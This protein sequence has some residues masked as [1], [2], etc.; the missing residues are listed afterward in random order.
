MTNHWIDLKNTNCA[1]IIGSNAAENHPISFKWLLKA[2]EER[3]ARI[4]SVDPRFTRTSSQADLY[5][6]LR[7]GTDIAFIGGLI[8]YAL[9][10]NLYFRDYVV[11]Y[12]NAAFLVDEGYS[13]H[14][15]LFDGYDPQTK[16]YDGKSWKYA[17]GL[18]E[19][20]LKDPTLTHPRTVF[21]LLKKH[22]SRYT[23]EKVCAITGT[24]KEVYLEVAK[25]YCATGRPDKSGTIMYAMGAT[26][27]TVGSQNVRSYAILQLLLGNIGVPG[28]GVNALRGESNVQGSTDMGLLFDQAPGYMALPPAAPEYANLKGYLDK[29]TPKAGFWT[30]KPKFFV[31]FLKAM[32]GEAATPGNQFGYAYLP[33][34]D[35][36][37]NYSYIS[38]FEDMYDGQIRGAF[39]FGQNS[40]I[41]GPNSNK[42]NSALDKLEWVVISDLWETETAAF[43]KR[44]GAKPAEIATEVFLLPAAA[45]FEKEGSITNSGRWIQWRWK[46]VNP[47]GEARSDLWIL[48]N[49]HRRI[50]ARYAASHATKD[51]PLLNLSWQYGLGEEPDIEAIA[52]EISG[53]DTRTG[54][55]LTTFLNLADDGT[56]VG[57]NWILGGMYPPEGNKAKSRNTADKG[58]IGSYLGWAF[59]WPANRRIL[60]NRSSADLHGKPWSNDKKVIWWDP[61]AGDPL[62]NEHG[63]WVGLDVPDFK[64]TVSPSDAGGSNPFIMRPEGVAGLFSKLNEGPFPEHYEP[65]ESPTAN[66]LSTVNLNPVVKI[67][68]S[69]MNERGDAEKFPIVVTT[70]RLSEHMQGGGMTRNLPWLAELMPELFVEISPTLAKARGIIPGQDVVVASA[71][72]EV[73]AKALVTNRWKPLMINGKEVE[74]IGLP[75][76]FGFMGIA[77]GDVAN[78]LTPHV[79]DGNTLIP[80]YKAFLCNIRG[81]K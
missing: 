6:P 12:T 15:G 38:L 33:K 53:Y 81:V 22:Y 10:N 47:P 54:Q 79:G 25:A 43:W 72:G 63:K 44:P 78:K 59:A 68:K 36:K 45:S 21:R 30:N 1:L 3:G 2:R 80:E 35:P 58:G 62:K 4:I 7:P 18:D 28:G 40:A 34:R 67:F 65:F 76:H 31:S 29:E 13:F 49:L 20:P 42:E 74:Q 14:D 52:R 50:R 39:F 8:N 23:V 73:K 27:H 16:K 69:P 70:F 19:K 66:S 56:T 11:N 9:E 75:W 61:V 60:Y 55:Q 26:Q 5:A 46:A 57:G 48:H 71:R 17:M 37:K 51:Q 32:Y 77:T 41:S 24:S 64:P